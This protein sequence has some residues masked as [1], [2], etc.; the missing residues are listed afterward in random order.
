MSAN[1]LFPREF[2]TEN[3]S[4]SKINKK[5]ESAM[6]TIRVKYNYDE[7]SEPEKLIIQTAR[8]KVPFGITSNEKYAK[9]NEALKWSIQL[10]FDN[11][12]KN[13][14]IA[15]FKQCI[16]EFDD[17]IIQQGLENSEEWL[18][19]DDPDIKSIKKAYKSGLKKFKPKKEKPD[20]KF[21]D[22][23]KISIPWDDE[24]NA[25]RN[26]VE[27]YDE[28]GNELEWTQVTP[29]CE[30][31]ALFGINGIWCFPGIN[32]FGP[33]IKLIQLQVFKPKK[34]KGFNIKVEA[35]SDDEESE[36][37]EAEAEEGS[38]EEE[39]EEVDDIEE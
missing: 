33:S 21:P 19:D 20:A 12:D 7:S 39:V 4:L 16:Q 9:E 8:V 34:I 22:T 18:N 6:G 26:N 17:Y 29:G 13:K 1:I 38:E 24:A 36:D 23:F 10:S 14:K 11:E 35:D 5:P 3:L 31:I 2:S 37:S 25:P 15:R 28:S 27:F 30:V 32:S